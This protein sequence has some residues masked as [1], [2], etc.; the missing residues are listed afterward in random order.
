MKLKLSL[1]TAALLSSSLFLLP[2]TGHA[3]LPVAVDGQQ[4]PTLAP[5]LEKVTPGVVSIQV[6]GAKE[7]RR[8]VDPFDFF[9]G[10]PAPRS[11][12]RPF[13]G[14]GSGVIIDA[15]EGYVVTNNHVIDEAD[16]I[17]VTL[18]DGREFKAELV[19]TDKESDIALLQIEGEDLTEVKLADSDKLRVGDFSVAIGNPFGLSHTVTSGIVSA[20][21][22]S[23]LNIEGYEDFIQTD[24]AINQGNS[25]GALVNLRGELIGINTAILGASGGNVGIGFAIPSNMMKNLVDQIIEYGQVRRGSL[26]IRGR[27]LDAG[28]A[29]AQGFDVKQGAFVQEVVKDS[30]ADE[31]GIKAN[32]VI[33]A[34]N[35][36]KIESFEELR[37]KIATLGEGKK[38]KIDVYRDGDTRTLKVELKGQS[39]QRAEADRIHPS[40]Q[41]AVL[42]SGERNGNQG[43]VVVSVEER[44]PAA[45]VGLQEGDVIM[46]VNRQRVAS[47][48]DMKRLIDD[49]Q[50][51]IVLGI[52]RGRDSVFYLIQ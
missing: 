42:E 52:K 26:G 8:R 13:S 11:Q 49:I 47:V 38:V 25:G 28:L 9:F 12:K 27:T 34:L 5:M 43:I 17:V 37:G 39:E 46:Q 50:G 36:D 10:N 35:G 48:R 24:A 21:G 51:N 2:E 15:D 40:L 19:G 44:S 32:D 33:I 23:G 14:L 22:R 18:K 7:V 3:R 20:L 6:S 4:L 45:R 16:N 41:G 1:L 30:A 29:K 31:A